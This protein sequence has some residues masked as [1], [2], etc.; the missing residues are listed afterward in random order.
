MSNA[1]S[2]ESMFEGCVIFNQDLS[3]WDVSGV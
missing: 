3:G 2:L 1:E